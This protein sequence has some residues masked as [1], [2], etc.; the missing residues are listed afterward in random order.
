MK[1]EI[2]GKWVCVYSDPE[3][4]LFQMPSARR[5]WHGVSPIYICLERSDI[6]LVNWE[7]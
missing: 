5:D 4:D 6:S 1:V 7:V 3:V 2:L